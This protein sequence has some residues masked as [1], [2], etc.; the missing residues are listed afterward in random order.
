MIHRSFTLPLEDGE[1]IRGD[2]RLPEGPPPSSAVI[3]V[4]GFKG[5]K[6]WGFFPHTCE[7]LAEDG[8]AVVSFNF[9][10][11]GIGSEP[12]E[13]TRLE[14]FARNHLTREVDEV[15]RVLREVEGGELLPG[16]VERIGLLGHSRGGGIAALAAREAGARVS[17]LVTWAAVATFDR[18]DRNTKETW[19]S[20][21][22]IHT[23][24]ARTGQEMPLDLQLL[25]DYEANRDRLDIEAAVAALEIPTLLI[26]GDAD[27]AVSVEDAHRLHHANPAT[28]LR[29]VPGAGHT[30]EARHPFAGTT[31]ELD[32]ALSATRGHFRR[33][34]PGEGVLGTDR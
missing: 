5:F 4:H 24:N 29:L 3:V 12:G 20:T 14:S 9:S 15:L 6:D 30:F 26:H 17:A 16:P 31:P 32:D 10:L 34:L 8:H 22:R 11:N 33:H 19:R 21:G 28:E 2:L 27:A 13:F 23:L 7:T 1:R 18:W 25:E